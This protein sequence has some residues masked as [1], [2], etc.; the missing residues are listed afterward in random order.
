MILIKKPETLRTFLQSCSN[1]SAP[2]GF[3]PT[4]GALHEGHA[5]LIRLSKGNSALT[6]V[7]I[8]VN[9]TQFN[10]PSDFNKYP[11]SIEED[12]L[13]LA[14]CG[15]DI[16][17]LPSVSEIYSGGT[18]SLEKYPLGYLETILEGKYRPGHFQG[19]CQVMHR[20]L[21]IVDPHKLFMGQ[22]D[23]QQCLVIAK[24]IELMK[25]KSELIVVPTLRE[26]D[27]LA[28][29]SRNRRL[30]KD[31]RNR[32]ATISAALYHIA[33]GYKKSVVQVKHEAINM[34]EEKKFRVDYVEV[35][36]AAT[37]EIQQEKTNRPQVALI[38]AFLGEVRLI[39]NLL[40]PG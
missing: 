40:L 13:L 29:S 12:I 5:K 8:F 11:S 22:K 9:P 28:L 39:D 20:L 24:L 23:Y 37:L 27:G 38:A 19:V 1:L 2:V 32:A 16:L 34:L 4:M 26:A 18:N 30:N 33:A 6:V 14:N 17:F 15:T 31:E 25:I 10:D 35:A 7:S 36:D 21:Q 3:V